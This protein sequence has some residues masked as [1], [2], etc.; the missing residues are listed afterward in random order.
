MDKGLSDE[1]KVEIEKGRQRNRQT[2]GWGVEKTALVAEARQ[3]PVVN[4]D[5]I[6]ACLR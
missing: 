4:G 6:A 3:G 2:L 5:A 1:S